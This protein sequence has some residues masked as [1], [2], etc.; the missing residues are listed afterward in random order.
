MA[1]DGLWIR[2]QIQYL[3]K[4]ILNEHISKITQ[5]S[6]KEFDFHIRKNGKDLI[7]TLSCNP[8][9]PYALLSTNEKSNLPVPPS[10]CM[11]LRK[12]VTG[13]KIIGIK[14]INGINEDNTLERIIRFTIS[15]ISPNGDIIKVNIIIEL[16]GKYSNIILTNE[17]NIIIDL[18]NKID[19]NLSN[20]KLLPGEKYQTITISQKKE[21]IGITY[22]EFFNIIN[23]N[24]T[25]K[26]INNEKYDISDLIVES[27]LGFSKSYIYSKT[28]NCNNLKEIYQN[29]NN[30]I[31]SIEN[32]NFKSYIY[33]NDEKIKDFHCTKL[34][35]YEY[36]KEYENTEICL[37]K[38]YEEKLKESSKSIDTISC[39]KIID[40]LILKYQKLLDINEKDLSKCDNY[41]K[42][43]TYGD[44]ILSFGFDAKNIHKNILI[45]NNYYDDNKEINIPLDLTISIEKNSK[46]YY[47]KYNKLKRTKEK[48]SNLLNDN[49]EK[50]NHLLSIKESIEFSENKEDI[51]NIKDELEYYF[52]KTDKTHSQKKEN[53]HIFLTHKTTDSGID[54][55]IGKNNIQNEY[56]SFKFANKNDTWFH[57]KNTTGAHVILKANFENCDIKDIEKAASY[58]AYYSSKKNENKVEVDYTLVK[59]LKKVKGK[60]PGFCIYHKNYSIVVKPLA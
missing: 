4:N 8:S 20:R 33:Y 26:K 21:F 3:K 46:K 28:K 2:S 38:F 42:Y 34:S 23:N 53:K 40:N 50:L 52:I 13:G 17:N 35:Q 7:L 48:V 5:N 47:D 51:K 59:E 18:V 22:D 11:L 44:L 32:N 31:E 41:E 14:Q 37:S 39:N 16:M 57:A 29:I 45:C 36:F 54:I 27:F 49:K 30:D 24:E 43:K 9:F 10:F 58:A 55:Y 1:Y 60:A 25:I 6:L 12:Y 19:T 56:L 15:N